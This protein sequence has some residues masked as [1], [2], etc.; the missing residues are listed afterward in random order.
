MKRD[1]LH[2]VGG[3]L[4]LS[5]YIRVYSGTRYVVQLKLSVWPVGLQA[6]EGSAGSLILGNILIR[7][8]YKTL[9]YALRLVLSTSNG[10]SWTVVPGM[11]GTHC[12]HCSLIPPLVSNNNLALL[13]C[14]YI[15]AG[16]LVH[17]SRHRGK[18]SN[19][20]YKRCQLWICSMP[21]HV[22]LYRILLRISDFMILL[23]RS[24][25]R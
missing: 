22:C 12:K 4:R 9:L 20:N 18:T 10:T 15:C 17:I 14:G 25:S 23:W 24:G 16:T 13:R 2:R 11:H 8:F 3:N 6:T 19:N 5:I 1:N 7:A 21:C